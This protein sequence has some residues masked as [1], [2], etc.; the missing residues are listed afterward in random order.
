M[1]YDS[2]PYIVTF[3]VGVTSA[4]FNIPITDDNIFEENETF[5]V[6]IDSFSLPSGVTIGDNGQFTMTIMDNDGKQNKNIS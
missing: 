5:E 3:P 1:D 2:G 6:S 4:Q